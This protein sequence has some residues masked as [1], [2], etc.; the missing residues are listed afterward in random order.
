[1]LDAEYA[2]Q[3]QLSVRTRQAI[4]RWLQRDSEAAAAIAAASR[5]QTDQPDPPQ[6]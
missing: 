2:R 4:E 5:A 6:G 1:V 3:R